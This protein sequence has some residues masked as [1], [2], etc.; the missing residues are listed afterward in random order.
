MDVDL[1]SLVAVWYA[2]VGAINYNECSI[3]LLGKGFEAF[4]YAIVTAVALA[5]LAHQFD[6][7][8][9]FGSLLPLGVLLPTLS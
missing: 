3:M 4:H 1:F 9:R 7:F 2:I 8:S 6:P 5:A